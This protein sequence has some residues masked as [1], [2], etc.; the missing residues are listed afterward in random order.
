[1]CPAKLTEA[2]L[3]HALPDML[4]SYRLPGLDGTIE[5]VRDGHGIPHVSATTMHDVFFGQGFAT[6]QDRLWHMDYDRRRAYGRWAEFAGKAAVEGDLLMRKMQI[7]ASVCRDYQALN[8]EAKMMLDAYS[9]R[10]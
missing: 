4:S 3:Q 9:Y 7:G 6:T 1:M 8:Q 10:V 5:I 2:D